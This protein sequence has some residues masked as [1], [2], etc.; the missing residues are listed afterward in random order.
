L[1]ADGAQLE[2]IHYL[3]APGNADA[4]RRD[5]EG[6]RTAVVVGGSYLGTELAASLAEMGLE[7]TMVFLEDLPLERH[8]GAAAG[9]WFAGLL[10]G[11]GIGLAGGRWLAA[12]TG[13]ADDRTN[14]RDSAAGDGADPPRVTGVRTEDGDTFPGELVVV[15]AGAV[16]DVMLARQ[17]GLETGGLGG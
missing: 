10:E 11:H 17:S 14:G 9:A 16:P 3:R 2:G 7:V 13:V 15:A 1:P 6:A 4:I 12:F 8:Y 5:A